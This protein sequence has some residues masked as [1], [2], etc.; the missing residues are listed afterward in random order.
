M[1]E[2]MYKERRDRYPAN[3]P[4]RA[5][6]LTGG[7]A[8]SHPSGLRRFTLAELREFQGFPPHHN[9]VG[10]TVDIMKQ[11]GNA[12]PANVFVHFAKKCIQ[13]L[14]ETDCKYNE[15][16]ATDVHQSN[17]SLGRPPL[18]NTG[19]ASS[20]FSTPSRKRGADSMNGSAEGILVLEK[21]AR[22]T[23][24][25]PAMSP[26]PPYSAPGDIALSDIPDGSMRDKI[27]QIQAELPKQRVVDCYCALL[28]S[29]GNLIAAVAAI[30]RVEEKARTGF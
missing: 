23:I 14:R 2:A 6:V 4:L 19:I 1:K 8:E 28:E 29:K 7:T 12:L 15:I 30:V 27:S 22:I 11:M 16:L 3:R 10:T 21:R 18:S 25:S 5:C 13:A 20:V 24:P 26:P 9:F 17:M